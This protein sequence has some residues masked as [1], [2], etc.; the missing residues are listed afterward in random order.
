MDM[1]DT[2]QCA[3]CG[4]EFAPRREHARFCS[5]SCRVAWNCQLADSP[6]AAEGVLDWSFAAMLEVT[7]RL[8]RARVLE[9]PRGYALITEAVWWCTMVDATLVRYHPDTY[10]A[11][12]A[13]CDPAE[14]QLIEDIFGGLR[15]VRNQMG[16]KADHRDFIQPA[17]ASSGQAAD[18]VAAW[19]WRPVPQPTLTALAPRGQDWEMTRYR[20]YQAQLAGGRIGDT[21]SRAARFLRHTSELSRSHAPG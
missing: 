13:D 15:F 1:V 2:R 5:T 4:A 9:R 10:V 16:Y 6:D 21:F 11:A 8:L 7:E 20:S 3:Q 14:R 18:R 19:I 17:S 12:L